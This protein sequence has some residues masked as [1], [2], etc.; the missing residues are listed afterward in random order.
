MDFPSLF[1]FYH[2]E[3][4]AFSAVVVSLSVCVAAACGWIYRIAF[5]SLIAAAVVCPV[6]IGEL[7]R[8]GERLLFVAIAIGCVGLRKSKLVAIQIA[9]SVAATAL[10]IC[11]QFPVAYRLSNTVAAVRHK[12]GTIA[13]GRAISIPNLGTAPFCGCVGYLHHTAAYYIVDRGGFVHTIQCKHFALKEKD[14]PAGR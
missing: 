3:D 14:A 12:I 4:Y 13:P 7:V 1:A 9:V 6:A 5:L 11:L 10:L 2:I 8:P